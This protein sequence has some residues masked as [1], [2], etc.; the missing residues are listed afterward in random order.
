MTRAR[1]STSCAA[2]PRHW[3]VGARGGARAQR[4]QLATRAR[5]IAMQAELERLAAESAYLPAEQRILELERDLARVGNR[6]AR[7]VAR[8]SC[9]CR[10]RVLA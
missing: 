7:G 6:G 3:R 5:L 9:C 10:P 8:P 4:R 2:S 1:R